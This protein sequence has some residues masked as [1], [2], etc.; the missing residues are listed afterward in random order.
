[1]EV[2]RANT[3]T[4]TANLVHKFLTFRQDISNNRQHL[5]HHSMSC[6]L[7][8]LEPIFQIDSRWMW[9]WMTVNEIYNLS[10]DAACE[11]RNAF[12][13]FNLCHHEYLNSEA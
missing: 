11:M 7:I 9:W 13:R 6:G 1:M 12:L 8:H 4:T 3:N 2:V 5:L 10:F